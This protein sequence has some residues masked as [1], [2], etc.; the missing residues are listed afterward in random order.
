MQL[1][2]QLENKEKEIASQYLRMQQEI[3][4]LE[5]VYK[6]RFHTF[7]KCY[8]DAVNSVEQSKKKVK[9]SCALL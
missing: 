1:R 7:E 2:N 5:D 4:H 8:R 9:H 3:K 6:K